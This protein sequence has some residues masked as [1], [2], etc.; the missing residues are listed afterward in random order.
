MLFPRI[1]PFFKPGLSNIVILLSLE[2]NIFPF[3]LLSVLKTFASSLAGGILFSPFF[4]ISLCQ[5]VLSAFVM[6]LIYKTISKKLISLYGISICGS[7]VSAVVQIFLCSLYLGKGVTGILGL[8]IIFNVFSG[9]LT[10]LVAGSRG[11]KTLLF[12]FEQI[13]IESSWDD[14]KKGARKTSGLSDDEKCITKK[15]FLI[16]SISLTLLFVV[17]CVSVFFIKNTFVLLGLFVMALIVQTIKG[18]K[19]RIMPYIAIWIFIFVCS[20]FMPE[21]E[22]LFI[23]WKFSLTKG[24]LELALQKALVLSCVAALSQCAVFLSFPKNSFMWMIFEYYRLM[25]ETFGKSKTRLIEFFKP[26]E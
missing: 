26:C 22:V 2:M 21:G 12:E 7:V 17:I 18:R 19:I 15:H 20:V 4:L 24:A 11:V 6:R 14:G 23:L 13:K 16:K 9:I 1:L 8:M 3:F 25:T 5:S 10:A